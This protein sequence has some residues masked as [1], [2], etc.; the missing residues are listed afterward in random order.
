MPPSED[1]TARPRPGRMRAP[2]AA[3]RRSSPPR[4]GRLSLSSSLSMVSRSSCSRSIAGLGF[5]LDGDQLLVHLFG[6]GEVGLD[7]AELVERQGIGAPFF[8]ISA[9]RW[10]LVFLNSSKPVISGSTT[11]LTSAA[12]LRPPSSL[13]SRRRGLAI[14]IVCPSVQGRKRWRHGRAGSPAPSPSRPHPEGSDWL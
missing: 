3:A 4:L 5:P 7:L 6:A 9:R 13:R 12:R 1:S 10:S 11:F 14:C 2:C 8:S